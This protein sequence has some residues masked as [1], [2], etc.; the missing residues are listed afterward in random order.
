L[1]RE[2]PPGGLATI[3]TQVRFEWLTTAA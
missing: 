3:L 2:T 1:V